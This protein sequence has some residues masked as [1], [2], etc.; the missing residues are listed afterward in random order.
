[1][2]P[3]TVATY[4]LG[5]H[6]ALRVMQ[7]GADLRWLRD[8]ANRLVAAASP[9][10]DKAPQIVGT[11]RLLQAGLDLIAGSVHEGAAGARARR[12]RNGL[13][14]AF[15]ALRPIRLANLSGL[16]LGRTL[17]IERGTAWVRIPG[18]EMKNHRPLEVPW[19]GILLEPLTDYLE[20]H[21]SILLDGGRTDGLWVGRGATLTK[22]GCAQVIRQVTR[23]A[24]GLEIPPHRFRDNAA[25]TIALAAAE[26]VGIIR[27]VL[28]HADHRTGERYYN[29]ATCSQAAR[30]V[31]AVVTT[32]RAE[33]SHGRTR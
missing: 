14:T 29:Q 30:P 32:M 3:T 26:E 10:R 1:L 11:D 16:G 18:T 6:E 12:H 5:L 17:F 33:R 27:A 31:Q 19:P 9:R 22:T 20:R 21:R 8:A 13:L 28:G 15:L 23:E 24:F 7:P 25:T 4:I 2:A